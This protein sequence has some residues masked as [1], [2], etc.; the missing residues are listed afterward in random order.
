MQLVETHITNSK[1]IEAICIKSKLL[2]N[3]FDI[4]SDFKYSGIYKITNVKNRKVYIGQSQCLYIRFKKYQKLNSINKHL[5]SAILKDGIDNFKVEI[6]ELNIPVS[7]LDF[8][9]EKYIEQYKS[10]DRLFGYN[11]C[12]YANTTRGVL[13][14]ERTKK[15]ISDKAKNRVMSD[16][17]KSKISSSNLGKKEVKK[18]KMLFLLK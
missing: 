4:N 13:H 18:L 2:Y 10:F 14:T 6:L 8:L 5:K 7:Q 15:T 1:E 17:T 11:I 16:L 12:R 3:I 9:E